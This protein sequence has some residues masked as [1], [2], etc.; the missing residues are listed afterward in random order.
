M[1]YI[2]GI[3]GLIAWIIIAFWPA[4]WA[5][6]KG[7]S[8]VLFLILSWLISF[9]LTL[10]IVALLRDKTETAQDRADDAAVDRA[11]EEEARRS[12]Q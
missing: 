4:W 8:F 10:I 3:I 6:Q 7:Y 5:K 1:E 12:Q 11:L 9:I 2:W